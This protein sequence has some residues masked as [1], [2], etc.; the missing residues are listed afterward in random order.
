MKGGRKRKEGLK[1]R[2]ANKQKTTKGDIRSASQEQ[3]HPRAHGKGQELNDSNEKRNPKNSNDELNDEKPQH[4]ERAHEEGSNDQHTG[5]EQDNDW[6][7]T[8]RTPPTKREE[9][10]KQE[11]QPQ[12]CRQQ[13]H[14]ETC[15]LK[16][17]KQ[18]R[19]NSR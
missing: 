10:H 13:L 14:R 8:T 18:T 6:T 9:G 3:E 16:I 5:A 4:R 17:E 11:Q 2:H 7:K 19:H 1:E 12:V 15:E